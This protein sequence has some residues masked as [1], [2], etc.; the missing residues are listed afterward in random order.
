MAKWMSEQPSKVLGISH[1]R[2]A[3]NKGQLADFV[4][5]KPEEYSKVTESYSKHPEMNVFNGQTLYGGIDYVWLR[6]RCAYS[7]RDFMHAYGKKCYKTQF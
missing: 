6:G 3:I 5:W 4:I 7:K 1:I 2:G